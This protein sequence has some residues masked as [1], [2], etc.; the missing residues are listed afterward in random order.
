ME[1]KLVYG[2]HGKDPFHI[3]DTLLLVKLSLEALGHKADLEAQMTPGKT[4]ILLECFT[5]DFVEAMKEVARTP[6]TEFIIIA[7]EFVTGDTFNDF[8]HVDEEPALDSHYD[9]PQYWRKRFRTFLLAQE[10]ARAIWH[11]ADSQ[12]DPFRQATGHP[13]VAYLPH[14]Y[15]EGFARVRH[16]PAEHKDIDAI[17]T[18]T[19]TR[20]RH[21]LIRELEQRGIRAV[22]T[23]PVNFVQ[24]EDLV[25]RAKIGLNIRQTGRWRYPSNSRYH[26]HL[27]NDSLL[28]SEQCEVKC[29]LSPYIIEADTGRFADCCAEWLTDNAWASEA[30]IR[31]E[32]FMSGM[33]MPELMARLLD[34]TYRTA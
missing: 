31:R 6:G 29:D 16:K 1:F 15:V 18:G 19:L 5:Y 27:S 4:N 20:H 25:A 10:K 24:R 30:R 8:S 12:V 32:Q 9:I 3:M 13:R 2:N 22:A 23:K 28:I 17:F 11:L 33:P 14:G 7:T 26:F 21:T 34:A